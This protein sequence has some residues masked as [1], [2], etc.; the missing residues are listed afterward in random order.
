MNLQQSIVSE[1][2]DGSLD[3][4]LRLYAT[5]SNGTL[6]QY[7]SKRTVSSRTSKTAYFLKPI[8]AKVKVIGYGVPQ[9]Y[10]AMTSVSVAH[11]RLGGAF[12]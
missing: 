4:D 8:V 11:E 3:L 12:V 1:C 9:T 7:V 2:V 6:L 5:S 10:V